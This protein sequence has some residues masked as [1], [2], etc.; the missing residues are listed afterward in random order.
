MN[1][2]R[3]DLQRALSVI[4]AQEQARLLTVRPTH[5]GHLRAD[6]AKS[7]GESTSVFLSST[8]G[9]VRGWRNEAAQARRALRR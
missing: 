3:C 5:G 2:R 7:T 1:R 9:D 8:P 4:A 6:F